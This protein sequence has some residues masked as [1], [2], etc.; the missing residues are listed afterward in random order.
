MKKKKGFEQ[1]TKWWKQVVISI[2]V[3]PA[4]ALSW[5]NI[6]L[7]WASPEKL[8]SVGKKVDKHETSQEQ[9]TRL[10]L[11]Q[12]ARLDKDDAVTKAQLDAV[13]EQLKLIAELRSKK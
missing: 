1:Y 8:D 13:K 12:Q 7:I 5:K 3:I 11:E 2:V 9:L 6:Q 4:F 10:M